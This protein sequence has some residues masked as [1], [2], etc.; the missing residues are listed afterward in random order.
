M[1]QIIVTAENPRADGEHAVM[2]IERVSSS[3]FES[4]HFQ[5]QLVERLGWA[6]G[7]ADAVEQDRPELPDGTELAQLEP[8]EQPDPK[9]LEP[10]EEQQQIDSA[11]SPRVFAHSTT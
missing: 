3:D 9:R 8:A 11:S 10:A 6:V 7:D 5:A 2:F 4:N 1:P